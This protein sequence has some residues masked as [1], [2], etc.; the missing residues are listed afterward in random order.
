MRDKTLLKLAGGIFT[1][2]ALAQLTRYFARVEAV[3]A[4][5]FVVPVGAS[6]AAGIVLGTLAFIYLRAGLRS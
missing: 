3:V 1:L 5:S 6:L 2:L 4:G